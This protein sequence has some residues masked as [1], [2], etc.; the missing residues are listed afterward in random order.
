M[1]DT[2]GGADP[3]LLRKM[4]RYGGPE[5]RWF[6]SLLTGKGEI[7][8]VVACENTVTVFFAND[9][10]ESLSVAEDDLPDFRQIVGDW[11][12]IRPDSFLTIVEEAWVRTSSLPQRTYLERL[13]TAI[14]RPLRQ[15]FS[16]PAA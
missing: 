6:L 2:E 5:T 7:S 13:C 3:K 14:N 12:V 9:Q 15:R 8:S 16:Q 1:E 4:E 11:T 10:E